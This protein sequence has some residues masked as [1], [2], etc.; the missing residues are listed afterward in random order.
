MWSSLVA[1]N[2][3]IFLTNE[4]GGAHVIRAGPTF[5]IERTNSIGEP[6]ANEPL[7][8]VGRRVYIRTHAHL[9]AIGSSASV[10]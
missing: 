8:P 9:F 4:D 3:R 1:Y 10:R 6:G 2:D 7:A 5:E